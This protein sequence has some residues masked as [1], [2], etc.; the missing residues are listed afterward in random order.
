MWLSARRPRL[1]PL[2]RRISRRGRLL[3][4]AARPHLYTGVMSA[5]RTRGSRKKG[6]CTQGVRGAGGEW[7]KSAQSG[8]S[9]STKR[10]RRT[11]GEPT[12]N[13]RRTSGEPTEPSALRFFSRFFKEYGCLVLFEV[14]RK[15]AGHFYGGSGSSSKSIY[16][17]LR[18]IWFF[19]PEEC[20]T[21]QEVDKPR[22]KDGRV[23]RQRQEKGSSQ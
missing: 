8:G 18:G 19:F 6:K 16:A 3:Y 4:G 5:Y 1:E 11:S 2:A 15:I 7:G 13:Q 22:K 23:L 21:G 12:E 9:Q 20:L 10:E 17:S 14:P